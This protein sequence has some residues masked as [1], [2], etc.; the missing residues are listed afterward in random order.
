M[1]G[2]ALDSIA[3]HLLCIIFKPCALFISS[4]FEK[5]L[6]HEGW[7]SSKQTPD[8]THVVPQLPNSHVA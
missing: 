7:R 1:E 5:Q 8:K 6:E 3:F 2:N 4:I